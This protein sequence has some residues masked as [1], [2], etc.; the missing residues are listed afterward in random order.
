MHPLRWHSA[1]IYLLLGLGLGLGPPAWGWGPQGHAAVG[2]LAMEHADEAAR[3]ALADILGTIDDDRI[4]ALC[5]WPDR[6]RDQPEWDWAAPQHYVN[7]PRQSER[8]D[9]ERDC[10]DGLCV[11][12]AIK[13]YA[14]ELMDDRLDRQ[15]REQ[16]FAWLC[17]LVADIHQ[18]LHAGFAD[19][20]GGNAVTVILDG[21]EAN[22]HWFWDSLV[23]PRRIGNVR[24]LMEDIPQRECDRVPDRWS[25]A[26]VNAWTEESHRLAG[27]VVYPKSKAI[28][29]RFERRSWNIARKRLGLAAE[30]F[31]QV[32]NA[33][34]GDGEVVVERSR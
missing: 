3:S 32:L 22:L 6:I 25:P 23:I 18:P 10:P 33:T 21:E 29:E 34:L 7:L 17:H 16:A 14:A 5:N 13:K 28:D 19:D 12:E 11:T 15:R 8:Y 31:A 1:T 2:I 24:E 20:R 30:R 9:A 27:S 26:D 4:D